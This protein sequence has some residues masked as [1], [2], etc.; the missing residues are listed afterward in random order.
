MTKQLTSLLCGVALLVGC[1]DEMPPRTVSE[2]VENPSMLEAVIVRCAQDRV[3]TKYDAECVNVREAVSRIEV[4]EEAIRRADFDVRSDR[5]RRALRR[6]R[7]AAAQSR[8]R[9]AESERLR[10][11]AEYLAQFGVAPPIESDSDV[12]TGNTPLAIIPDSNEQ[13]Q[14]SP[15]YG[16]TSPATDGGNAPTAVTN[17]EENGNDD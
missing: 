15:G 12:D 13:S 11:E 9:A 1:V 2:L 6:A 10:Q 8:R 5:K 3:K 4:K 17:P 14:S 7:E 16:E